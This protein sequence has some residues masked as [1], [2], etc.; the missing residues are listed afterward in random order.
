M[1]IR[2]N[3]ERKIKRRRKK[4]SVGAENFM[5]EEDVEEEWYRKIYIRSNSEKKRETKRM[6]ISRGRCKSGKRRRRCGKK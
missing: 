3:S 4:D 5:R 6:K 1:N 2:Y